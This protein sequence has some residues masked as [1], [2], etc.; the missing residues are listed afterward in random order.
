MPTPPVPSHLRRGGQPIPGPVG[1]SA[2]I[3]VV[4]DSHGDTSYLRA[5]F[6]RADSEGCDGVV[7]LGDFGFWPDER[8]W[9]DTDRR[10]LALNEARLDEVASYASTYGM[11]MRVLD[12]NHDAHPMVRE[13]YPELDD[14]TGVRPIRSRLLDWA[15]RGS[16]WTWCGVRFG[17]LGGGVSVDRDRRVEGVTWWATETITETEL[18]RLAGRGQVDVLLTHDGPDIE[19]P[20]PRGRLD[21]QIEERSRRHRTMVSRAVA[22]AAPTLVMHG[23]YHVAYEGRVDLGDGERS[24][25]IGLASNLQVAGYAAILEL[26]ALTVRPITV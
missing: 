14:G 5:Q 18:A 24:R 11:W 23:H 1:D 26:P 19:I 6:G 9:Y 12:G 16:V 8:R 20:L 25:V 13:Q 7:Q 3:L 22:A 21:P 2:R 15:D 17:A 10:E 4:G